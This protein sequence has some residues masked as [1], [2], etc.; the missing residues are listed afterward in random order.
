[1]TSLPFLKIDYVMGERFV[2]LLQQTAGSQKNMTLVSWLWKQVHL[3]GLKEV[4][5]S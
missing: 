5:E 1:M 4:D 2:L 3:Q